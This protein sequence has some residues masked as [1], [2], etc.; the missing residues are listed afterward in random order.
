MVKK[1]IAQVTPNKESH[2]RV[3]KTLSE[4]DN[5]QQITSGACED[6]Q[7][8]INT[9]PA[10]EEYQHFQQGLSPELIDSYY[11]Q[12]SMEE[13]LTEAQAANV[14]AML[15]LSR[16]HLWYAQFQSYNKPDKDLFAERLKDRSALAQSRYWNEQAG[17]HGYI[18][19]FFGFAFTYNIELSELK[20]QLTESP[21]LESEISEQIKE[22]EYLMAA[23]MQLALDVMPQLT[24]ILYPLQMHIQQLQAGG[25]SG[26][27]FNQQEYEQIYQNVYAQWREKRAQLGLPSQFEF[28]LTPGITHL[29]KL[30]KQMFSCYR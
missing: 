22:L 30:E 3:D 16:K 7:Q 18:G 20:Q 26:L 11:E 9:H 23:Y 12:L 2:A 8:Q 25:A 13:L 27:A 24:D 10:A 1:N 19:A 29:M 14:A 21:E 28:S 17:L 15:M 5:A 4:P 6:I